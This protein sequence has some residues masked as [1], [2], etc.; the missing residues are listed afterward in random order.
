MMEQ[1]GSPIGARK[2]GRTRSN[3]AKQAE[4]DGGFLEL[5][6]LKGL[7]EGV[8]VAADSKGLSR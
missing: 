3:E 5:Q 8:F 4:S 6:I 1:F 7:S 2:S